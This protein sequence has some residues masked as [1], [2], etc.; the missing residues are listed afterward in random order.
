MEIPIDRIVG[1][2]VLDITGRVLGRVGHLMVD[3]ESWT[4]SSFQLKLRRRPA[5]DMG[6]RWSIFHIPTL[7]V[8]TGLVMAASD[9]IILRAEM[10]DLQPLAPSDQPSYAQPALSTH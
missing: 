2:K 6:V 10:A 9:A 7:E 3:T 5:L 1:R 4:I 8:P